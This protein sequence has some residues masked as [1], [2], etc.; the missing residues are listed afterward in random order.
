M[1][2][3]LLK[4]LIPPHSRESEMMVLGSMLTSI[5]SL[6]IGADSLNENDFYFTE[7][8]ILFS[9]LK[10]AYVQDKP[11]DVHL[12]SEE[13][14]RQN[15][16]QSVGGVAFVTT[17]AQ[18]AGTSAYI[19]EY[20]ELVR[21]KSILRRMIFAA[22]EVEKTALG[23]PQ[24]VHTM[25]DEAQQKFF[26]ISQTANP[27]MG[28]LIADLLGG[29][30]AASQEPYLKELQSRQELF[31]KRGPQE[32]LVTGIPTHFADLDKI[33]NG[34]G[35]SNLVIVAG[36]PAMGK[37]A[38]ALNIAENICFNSNVPVGIFSLEMS[39][40]QLLHRLICSQSEVESD[41]IKTGSLSGEEYR[42]IVMAVNHMKKFT[43]VID[44]QP[45]LKITDLRARARRMK[46]AYGIGILIVDYLQLLSGSGFQRSSENR[47]NEISEISRMLKNLARELNIPIICPSQLSRKVEDRAGHRPML[48]DLRES[49]CLTG[50]ALITDAK[51]GRRIPIKELAER[52]N[53]EPVYVFAVNDHYQVGEHKLIKAFYS[54]IK[55]V[56]EL[57]T[58]TGKTIKAS[59]NHPFLT[60]HGWKS[61]DSLS[62]SDRIA[63]TRHISPKQPTKSLS[64][65]EAILLGH[66]LG[67]GCILPKQPYHYTSADS[68]NLQIVKE[69]ANSLFGIQSKLVQQ[70]NWY[71]LYLPSPYPL[72]RNKCHPITSWFENLGLERVRSYEKK[73]PEAL[74][75]SDDKTIRLFLKHLWATDGNISNKLIKGRKKSAAIYYASSS[76]QLANQVQHLLLRTSIPS[77]VRSVPSSKGYRT[78][79]HVA[80]EGKEN[81]LCF[82]KQIGSAGTRG[83]IIP[84]L[85]QDL[86]KIEAHPNYDVIPKGAWNLY[87][88]PARIRAGLSWRDV[89]SKLGM[90]YCGS[91]LFR[92]GISRER[93][94][95]LISFLPEKAL[96]NLA[97]QPIL[98]DE[99]VSITPLGEEPVYDATVEEVHNFLANDI[100][101]HNSIEQDADVV[102]LLFRRE[103]YDPYDKPGQ[104]EV[105]IGKNRH[106]GVGSVN[107]TFRK[108]FAQFANYSPLSTQGS[109]AEE[110]P[111]AALRT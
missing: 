4:P 91:S 106:G 57:R 15:K 54:G 66:L 49:G 68:E 34:L 24:D 36:R 92:S 90:S 46:E 42:R 64:D 61:L 104:A 87:V 102:M 85:I 59:A 41:K 39:A 70:K 52:K 44:D 11:I 5:N 12:A 31:K 98:W 111:F 2:E 35:N 43:M 45:G 6:N 96:V 19:E 51:T 101:V 65:E 79:Y 108:E 94:Q 67:D 7:H 10:T 20:V 9:I 75:Q 77:T 86:E 78:M 3:S 76:Q 56:F 69:A 55:Q 89:A 14:K 29:A 16:L 22:Q 53:Q 100:F 110:D 105:I 93:M 27:G 21:N 33:I 32:G 1:T 26:A 83:Q 58:R 88:N 28:V 71:H 23:D 63:T 73:V 8:K 25:L 48:S 84:S 74:F 72:T 50:D 30:K 62:L 60:I 103:Y 97:E 95:R 13:L 82:L 37:T 38:F 40:E 107:L 80:I 109:K 18:Y 99:I 17:L 81:Q 47:Q